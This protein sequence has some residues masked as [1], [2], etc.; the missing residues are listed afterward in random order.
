ML[1]TLR[2]SI[3]GPEDGDAGRRFLQRHPTVD[4]H[5]HPGR[6]FMAGS[7][8]TAVLVATLSP[9]AVD[10]AITD[11]V[12]HGPTATTFAAVSDFAV[13]EG[14]RHG[15]RPGRGFIEGEA[16]EDH[17]R[18]LALLDDVTSSTGLRLARRASD[19]RQAHRE[20][21]TVILGSVEG[22]DF[23]EHNLSRIAEAHARGVGSITLV[24]YRPNQ[25]GS[26]QTIDDGPGLTPFGID[27][28]HEMNRTGLLIDLS[29][30]DFAT[31]E[32][33]V[34]E[35]TRPCS[36]SHTNVRLGDSDHPRLVSPEHARLVTGSGGII[37]AVPAGFGQDTFSEYIDTII[38]MVEIL[39]V[40]HVAIGTDMDFTFRPVI[41]SYRTWPAIPGAL[42]ARGMTEGEVAL[43]LGGNVLRILDEVA[44]APGSHR[45][46]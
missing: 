32:R 15:V 5:S 38:R 28:I 45:E 27:V 17:L 16:Y 8:A 25:I 30:A 13:L 9:P 24:H 31:T 43:V 34:N 7:P 11:I 23:I 40:D 33:A 37:G 4:L 42:L 22:G 12:R 39:G 14:D 46:S 36:L 26:P 3:S 10:E 2:L 21:R 44:P 19:V 29:H 6:F 18:Q 20:K 1:P 41:H 35:S